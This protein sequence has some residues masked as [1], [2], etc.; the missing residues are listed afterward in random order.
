MNTLFQ[1]LPFLPSTTSS[2]DLVKPFSLL[3]QF[4]QYYCNNTSFQAQY[5]APANPSLE[6]NIS[7]EYDHPAVLE[8]IGAVVGERVLYG[9]PVTTIG[10]KH[11]IKYKMCV[12]LVKV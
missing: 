10:K 6:T 4:P 9:K 7:L 3:D 5:F 1:T 11:Y 8:G 2:S 12:D